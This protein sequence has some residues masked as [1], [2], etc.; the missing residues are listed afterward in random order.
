MDRFYNIGGMD[1]CLRFAGDALIPHMTTALEHLGVKPVST[2]ALTVCLWDSTSTRTTMPS[3]P[4]S[5]GDY[6]PR[7][8]IH[9]YTNAR[10]HTAFHPGV[11]TL[12][13]FDNGSNVG[14]F[15]IHAAEEIPSYVSG[16]PLHIIFSWWAHEHGLQLVHAAAVGTPIGGV[17]IVGKGGTGK[18]T[19]ALSCLQAG[20]LYAGDDYVLVD[21]RPV[22]YSL[23]NSAKL[24]S[25]Q[26]HNFP[27]LFSNRPSF[28]QSDLE[29]T[30]TFL[31]RTHPKQL[32]ASLP[33]VAILLPKISHSP[34]SGLRRA[35][36]AQALAGLAP[37]TLFQLPGEDRSALHDLARLVAQV[38]NY[39]LHLGTD[40]ETIPG[41]I[42]EAITRS[43][44]D[45]VG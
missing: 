35:S 4:W 29:K 40:L 41:A 11:G 34:S 45:V 28:R 43:K 24:D 25:H 31:Y 32:A 22:V 20:F 14:L 33:I 39:V 7:G 23:Y 13:L 15:W 37:S 42:H 17:L 9:G 6:L 19:T 26:S 3:P 1:I 30:L 2:P 38:P 8:E 5:M 16:S 27:A 18:S 36:T 44:I 12:S 10:I 21:D